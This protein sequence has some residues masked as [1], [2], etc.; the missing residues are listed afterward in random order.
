MARRIIT[1]ILVLVCFIANAQRKTSDQVFVAADIQ[2]TCLGGLNYQINLDLYTEC[3]LTGGILENQDFFLISVFSQKL[4]ISIIDTVQKSNTIISERNGTP[5]KLLCQS[6]D[7]QCE[8]GNFSDDRGIKKYTYKGQLDLSKYAVTDDWVVSWDQSSRSELITTVLAEQPAYTENIINTQ[9]G[10]NS[11]PSFDA[12]SIIRVTSGQTETFDLGATDANGNQLRYSLVAPKVRIDEDISYTGGA[13]PTNPISVSTP[14]SISADGKIVIESTAGDANG[15]VDILVE[16]LDGNTVVGTSRKTVQIASIISNNTKPDI[17]GFDGAQQYEKTI[18]AGQ[19]LNQSNSE[20][21]GTDADGDNMRFLTPSNADITWGPGMIQRSIFRKNTNDANPSFKY[22]SNPQSWFDWT[23]SASDTGQVIIPMVLE[24]DQCPEQ[25]IK[26]DIIINVNPIPDFDLGLSKVFECANPFTLD[27]QPT[28]GG[29][30]ISYLWLEGTDTLSTDPTFLVNRTIDLTLIVTDD[31]GCSLVDQVSYTN[32]INP[33]IKVIQN[34]IDR[35]TNLIDQSTF[36]ESNFVSRKWLVDTGGAV[37]EVLSLD[38]VK[39]AYSGPGIYP[40]DLVIENDLGCIDTL[41]DTVRIF[42][43]PA[44][45]SELFGI[46]DF[47]DNWA[48]GDLPTDPLTPERKILV[49]E[50]LF[51][52]DG[53]DFIDRTTYNNGDDWQKITWRVLSTDSSLA[54]GTTPIINN[55]PNDLPHEIDYPMPDSGS[56]IIE[57]ALVTGSGCIDTVYQDISLNLRPQIARVDRDPAFAG[58]YPFNCT[59]PD[60]VLSSVVSSDRIGEGPLEWFWYTPTDLELNVGPQ[61]IDPVTPGDTVRFTANEEGIYL[62]GVRDSAGCAHYEQFALLDVLSVNGT[63]SQPCFEGDTVIFNDSQTTT[64]YGIQSTTWNFGDGNQQ[65]VF[66]NADR[67]VKHVYANQNEYD[68]TLTVVDNAGCTASETFDLFNTFPIKQ[69]GDVVVT[70]P[71]LLTSK[72]CVANLIEATGFTFNKKTDVGYGYLVN[73]IRWTVK[74]YN[75]GVLTSNTSYGPYT[76]TSQ[77]GNLITGQQQ[78]HNMQATGDSVIISSTILYNGGQCRDTVSLGDAVQIFPEFKGNIFDNRI[79]VGDSG[80]FQ[81]NRTVNAEIP[82]DKAEW[83]I[84]SNGV[85]L[86]TYNDLEPKPFID[87]AIYRTS[88]NYT[89]EATITDAN[90]CELFETRTFAVD[91]VRATPDVIFENSCANQPVLI[92]VKSSPGSATYWTLKE[93]FTNTLDSAKFTSPSLSNPVIGMKEVT[94][95]RS[96]NIDITVFIVNDLSTVTGKQCRSRYDTTLKLFDIPNM[97]IAYDTVCS[98]E[99]AT[100]FENKTSIDVDT[101]LG[102]I[103]RFDWDFGD[104]NTTSTSGANLLSSVSNVYEKGG[105]YDLRLTGFTNKGCGGSGSALDTTVY[106]KQT[107]IVDYY[108]QPDPPVAFEDIDFFDNSEI[109]TATIVDSKWEFQGLP[110]FDGVDPMGIQWN[111]VKKFDVYHSILT[112]EGCFADTVF[113]IDLNAY[114]EMANAFSPNGD[115]INDDIGLMHRNIFELLEFKIFN[116][117]GQEV[118]DGGNDLNARWDGTYKSAEQ[119]VSV[120]VAHAKAIDVYGNEYNFKRNVRLIR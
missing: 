99:F 24:D 46:C 98:G 28:H 74:S 70:D 58:V 29:N 4:G 64:P 111:E 34:C 72:I 120:Y 87:P 57:M 51:D 26:Q 21:T 82:L 50:A 117:W 45:D 40:V 13:N 60:T 61:L 31:A 108:T 89:V 113:I 100:V 65:Q 17:L 35:E 86:E 101:S 92:T 5:I 54:P 18:C 115:G 67:P 118:F 119:E 20:L 47:I 19:T 110:S 43:H 107:P 76:A 91:S 3:G 95:D 25:S 71:D 69:P 41:R 73:D 105:N 32:S 114:F 103:I 8:T 6:Q 90:G 55:A 53:T 9:A 2:H 27:P 33:D 106:V 79:C 80:V 15:I 77:D 112:S 23:P 36:N 63:V 84:I 14:L 116:R 96:G 12:L 7:S 42:D 66:T 49:L 93:G 22:A 1:S 56:Y 59:S 30:S 94:F 44:I 68:I 85:V 48:L 88:G 109:G 38:T 62:V 81:L 52:N 97:E 39:H 104:G 37:M 83:K 75:E 16:E 11:S 10:C 102:E 78:L